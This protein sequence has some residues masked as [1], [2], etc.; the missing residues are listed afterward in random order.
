MNIYINNITSTAQLKEKHQNNEI[1][2]SNTPT[3]QTRLQQMQNPHNL[4]KNS[5]NQQQ[6]SL[7]RLV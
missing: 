3:L 4:I 6:Q 7:L 5:S 1:A 2:L